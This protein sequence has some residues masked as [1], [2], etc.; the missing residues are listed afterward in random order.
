METLFSDLYCKY[1]LPKISL[2]FI[3]HF[4]Y[5]KYYFE[6]R[7]NQFLVLNIPP[8]FILEDACVFSCII[9]DPSGIYLIKS[10]KLEIQLLFPRISISPPW[11]TTLTLSNYNQFTIYI[12]V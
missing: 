12:W 4:S 1:Y 2:D 3:S 11:H 10:N 7:Y 5:V 9:A 8:C 6:A